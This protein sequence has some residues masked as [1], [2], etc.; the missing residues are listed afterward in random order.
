MPKHTHT[1]KNKPHS[2]K[3]RFFHPK[4]E[5][6]QEK[7]CVTQTVNVE[8]NIDQKADCMTSCFAGLAKCFGK[9]GQ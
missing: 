5:E 7:E 2:D 1:S 8:V 9:G 3:N 6:K 4:K